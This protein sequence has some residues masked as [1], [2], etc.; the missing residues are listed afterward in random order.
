MS[1]SAQTD[2]R[3]KG[4]RLT[5]FSVSEASSDCGDGTKL[6]APRVCD[7]PRALLKV[8]KSN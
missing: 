8:S 4:A 3:V 1:K 5:E 7:R 2:E 6:E